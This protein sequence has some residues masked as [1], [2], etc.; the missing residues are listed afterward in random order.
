[1]ILRS[2]YNLIFIENSIL[3]KSDV[4]DRGEAMGDLLV[5]Y[6]VLFTIVRCKARPS[7]PILRF[8]VIDVR[9]IRVALPTQDRPVHCCTRTGFIA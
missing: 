2:R 4:V 5:P 9:R 3:Q 8:C 6:Y 7:V 1:M